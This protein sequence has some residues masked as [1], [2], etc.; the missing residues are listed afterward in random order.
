MKFTPPRVTLVMYGSEADRDRLRPFL[1]RAV[2]EAGFAPRAPMV[3]RPRLRLVA[4]AGPVDRTT[5]VSR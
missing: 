3:S 2:A 1:A 4:S 5:E